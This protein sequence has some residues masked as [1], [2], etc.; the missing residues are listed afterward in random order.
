MPA[1]CAGRLV[2]HGMVVGSAQRAR[3][4]QVRERLS[5]RNQED[6]IRTGLVR[7]WVDAY[8]PPC[9]G[10]REIAGG[11]KA[12]KGAGGQGGGVGGRRAAVQGALPCRRP[13]A[14]AEY[15]RRRSAS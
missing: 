11:A 8:G 13:R 1:G 15:L 10:A 9:R 12:R 6:A 4:R 14:D 5:R 2:G 3:G 7:L